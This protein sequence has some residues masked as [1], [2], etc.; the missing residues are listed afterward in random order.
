MLNNASNQPSKFRTKI[1]VEI[2]DEF[3]GAYNTNSQIKFKTKML[4]S[5]LCDYN[6]AYILVK[7]TIKVNNTA[8]ADA[9]ANDVGTKVMFKHCAAFTDCKSDIINVE[10]DNFKDIDIVM[11]MWNLMEYG[12][13][14]SKTSGSL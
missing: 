8:A 13:N 7:G 6:D 5:S 1:W 14:Y 11:P 3:R 12:D 10:V 9:N 4:K 2:N